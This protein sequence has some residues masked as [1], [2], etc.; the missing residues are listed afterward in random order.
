MGGGLCP[1]PCSLQSAPKEA[2]GSE[3]LVAVPTRARC[4]SNLRST[5]LRPAGGTGRGG[6]HQ[7][8]SGAQNDKSSMSIFSLCLQDASPEA[9]MGRPALGLPAGGSL[10]ALCGQR[11]GAA[12]CTFGCSGRESLSERVASAWPQDRADPAGLWGSLPTHSSWGWPNPHRRPS[13]LPRTR[14]PAAPRP[15]AMAT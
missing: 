12:P 14:T 4:H 1:Q 15:R 5:G 7:P 10:Y 3:V 6:P 8:A 13:V 11:V 2:R 9:G